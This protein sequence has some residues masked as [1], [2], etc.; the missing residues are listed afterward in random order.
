SVDRNGNI[1]FE[2]ETLHKKYSPPFTSLGIRLPAGYRSMSFREKQIE[3]KPLDLV[4]EDRMHGVSTFEL[5]PGTANTPIKAEFEFRSN[6][7]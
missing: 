2:I 3:G 4:R 7:S 1:Q 5:P 6:W